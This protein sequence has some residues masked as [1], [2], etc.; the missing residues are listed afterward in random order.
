MK[1]ILL[2]L[3]CLSYFCGTISAQSGAFAQKDTRFR[4]GSIH[5]MNE[6][7]SYSIFYPVGTKEYAGLV[8]LIHSDQSSNPNAYGKLIEELLRENYVIIFPSYQ[9]F[10]WSNNKNDI[11]NIN[12]SL[13]KAY[14]DI[15][16]NYP[17]VLS[18]PVAFIGHSMGGIIA[19]ELASVSPGPPKKPSAVISLTP[20]EVSYHKINNLNFKKLDNYD[21]YLI[22]EEENDKFYKRETGKRIFENL[23]DAGRKKHLSYS[24]KDGEKSKHLNAWSFDNRFSSNNNGAA[25]YF[26]KSIGKTNSVDEQY[27]WPEIK[28]ALRCAFSRQGCEEFRTDEVEIR[29]DL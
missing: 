18:L 14:A 20:A 29:T 12:Q 28:A 13:G 8:I 24:K 25:S 21:V 11:M 19:F 16:E 22:L 1:H 10:L 15:E 5:K 2:L 3:F 7:N 9:S 27:Y 17:K 23:E 26:S 4:F 6:R